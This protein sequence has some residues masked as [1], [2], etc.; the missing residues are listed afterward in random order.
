MVLALLPAMFYLTS[1]TGSACITNGNGT[2]CTSERQFFEFGSVSLSTVT[3]TQVYSSVV[4]LPTPAPNAGYQ[5]HLDT[6]SF[7]VNTN[8][9]SSIV[10][11]VAQG[12]VSS[13]QGTWTNMP[14]ATTELF[15]QA[16][17]TACCRAEASLAG[18]A[19]C[20]TV[21]DVIIVSNTVNAR[22]SVQ[23]AT[24]TAG[25]WTDFSN[26]NV[27]VHT[28]VNQPAVSNDWS[29]TTGQLAPVVLRIVGANGGGAGDNPQFGAIEIACTIGLAGTTLNWTSL[30]T[31]GFTVF[32]IL[33]VASPTSG[34]PIIIQWSIVGCLNSQ[35][36]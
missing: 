14:A 28:L 21:V 7:A 4:T 33:V 29:P 17:S 26:S 19:S 10:T 22:L 30:S 13:T 35:P 34:N 23:W 27:D 2:S 11:F 3:G 32:A 12:G 5:I 31:T 15:S 25:P 36:C 8:A 9:G 18:F 6:S 1:Q 20:R 24:G 16:A